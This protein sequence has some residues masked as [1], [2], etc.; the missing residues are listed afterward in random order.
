MFDLTG[1]VFIVTGATSELGYAAAKA[2][3]A[4]GAKVVLAGRR[5]NKGKAV[6]QEIVDAGGSALFVTTDVSDKAQLKALVDSAV[7]KYG[8]L[9]GAVNNAGIAQPYTPLH[10][11][12]DDFMDQI[13][14]VNLKSVFYSMKYE[15]PEL[16]KAGG[17][18][19]VNIS[20]IGGLRGTPGMCLYNAT[21]AGV[22]GL[23]RGAAM[24]YARQ[25]IRI[26][27]VCPG[28]TVSEIFNGVYEAQQKA[29]AETIPTGKFGKAEEIAALI[30][31]LCA[32]ETANI[33][34][35]NIVADN[36][37]STML[38]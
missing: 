34:G 6:E 13:V 7:A 30:V 12:D 3:A 27:A 17:G 21:K 26:N 14:N 22:L 19:I 38:L 29:I 4:Q 10:E 9:D 16:L 15:I 24:D 23:T 2:L 25:N 11:V 32:D 35:T 36:G 31:S 18:S 20:S 33:T 5:E 1:K 37:Q 28:A 8:R